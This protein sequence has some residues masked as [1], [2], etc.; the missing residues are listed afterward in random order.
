ME[1]WVTWHPT[2]RVEET[3]WNVNFNKQS[4]DVFLYTVTVNGVIEHSVVNLT[5]EK[6]EDIKVYTGDDF[7]PPANAYLKNLEITTTP[8]GYLIF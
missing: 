3:K 1:A 6:F 5:P 7:Y 2:V 8:H 4:N